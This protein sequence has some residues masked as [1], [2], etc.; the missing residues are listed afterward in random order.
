MIT[1]EWKRQDAVVPDTVSPHP[2]HTQEIFVFPGDA[3]IKEIPGHRSGVFQLK[4]TGRTFFFWSQEK[5]LADFQRKIGE[6]QTVLDG[7]HVVVCSCP[8]SLDS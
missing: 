6:I 7:K 8:A 2:P 1:F 3:V 4:D 5:E